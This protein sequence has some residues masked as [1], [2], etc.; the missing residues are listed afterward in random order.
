MTVAERARASICF[1]ALALFCPL[2][3]VD[4]RDEALGSSL[5]LP[6]SWQSE[7]VLFADDRYVLPSEDRW[8][9]H[10]APSDLR[11]SG[12]AVFRRGNSVFAGTRSKGLY[13]SQAG[14]VRYL[15]RRH[16][17]LSTYVTTVV[18]QGDRIFVGTDGGLSIWTGSV[19]VSLTPHNSKLPASLVSHLCL[20]GEGGVWV[21]CKGGGARVLEDFRVEPWP[22]ADP[23]PPSLVTAAS[24]WPRI[25]LLLASSDGLHTLYSGRWYERRVDFTPL[26]ILPLKEGGVL[27][28]SQS[29]VYYLEAL[30]GELLGPLGDRGGANSLAFAGGKV[31]AAS[32]EGV[33]LLGTVFELGIVQKSPFPEQGGLE[34]RDLELS[35]SSI[36]SFEDATFAY[37]SDG[38][39]KRGE[40]SSSWERLW[41]PKGMGTS[42][43]PGVKAATLGRDGRLWLLSEAGRLY[44]SPTLDSDR[45]NSRELP[46]SDRAPIVSIALSP[47][48]N[49]LLLLGEGGG[50]TKVSVR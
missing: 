24:R 14:E 47:S 29:G 9:L 19:F 8:R 12:R 50:L 36:F 3:D 44:F 26:D 17:L 7:L 37:G 21:V 43:E 34:S 27:L 33:R 23:G 1:L 48:G 15:R 2:S 49:S 30:G 18:A 4:A 42:S 6:P 32:A 20:D 13:I 40:D 46:E 25:G 28:A 41:P 45:W 39:F 10:M 35:F 38:L 16:G 5:A 22:K 11:F 31:W